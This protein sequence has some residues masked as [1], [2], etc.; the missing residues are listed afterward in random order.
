MLSLP[1]LAASRRAAPG[2]ALAGRG[3][4][5]AGAGHDPPAL[6]H[7]QFTPVPA[8]PGEG[9]RGPAVAVLAA[10]QGHRLRPGV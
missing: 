7:A 1:N 6:L 3:R 2:L 10:G 8:L 9:G 5:G 4:G